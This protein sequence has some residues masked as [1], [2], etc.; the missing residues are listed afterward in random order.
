MMS[1][2][3]G[4]FVVFKY[5]FG[6]GALLGLVGV[7]AM[8]LWFVLHL[9]VRFGLRHQPADRCLWLRQLFLET[10]YQAFS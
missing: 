3:S 9:M 4:I 5:I 1:V 10:P 7:G 2:L 6:L 8:L